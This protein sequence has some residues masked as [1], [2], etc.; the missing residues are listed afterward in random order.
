MEFEESVPDDLVGKPE[1][2]RLLQ[3]HRRFT[4]DRRTVPFLR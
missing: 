4:N 3:K 2:M 1:M